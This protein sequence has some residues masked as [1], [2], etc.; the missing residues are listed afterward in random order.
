MSPDSGTG[1][2]RQRS[3]YH[4]WHGSVDENRAVGD[5]AP[6]PVHTALKVEHVVVAPAARTVALSKYS[7]ADNK[8]LVDI[9]VDAPAGV[10]LVKE[11]VTVDFAKRSFDLRIAPVPSA[12]ASATSSAV[13]HGLAL[14]LSRDIDPTTSRFIVKPNRVVIKLSKAQPDQTWFDLVGSKANDDEE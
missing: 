1:V 13:S 3:Q 6:M 11:A 8:A 10:E 12:D 5:V 2:P 9:Y 7:W 14:V 4:Y